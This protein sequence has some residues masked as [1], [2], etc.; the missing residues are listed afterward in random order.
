[1]QSNSSKQKN[2]ARNRESWQPIWKQNKKF[3]PVWKKQKCQWNVSVMQ[4]CLGYSFKTIPGVTLMLWHCRDD[5]CIPSHRI[6]PFWSC[7]LFPFLEDFPLS[8]ERLC[9]P[10][11]STRELH[12]LFYFFLIITFR[13]TDILNSRICSSSNHAAFHAEQAV[14]SPSTF[15]SLHNVGGQVVSNSK[16][17]RE[18]S[19]TAAVRT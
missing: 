10:V 1:M 8:L 13:K 4:L 12:F 17:T 15:S 7:N 2:K 5:K 11:L 18:T 19:Q 9:V 14:Q 16:A 6:I 3:F